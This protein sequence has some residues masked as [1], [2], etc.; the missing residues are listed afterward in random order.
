MGLGR[1]KTQAR[2]SAVEWRSKTPNVLAFS[3]EAHVTMP[4]DAPRQKTRKP[5]SSQTS[6]ARHTSCVSGTMCRRGLVTAACGNK[7]L[8][9]FAPYTF[10]FH[11]A[12]VNDCRTTTPN[13]MATLLPLTPQLQTCYGASNRC[14]LSANNGREQMQQLGA[15]R[16]TRSPHQHGQAGRTARQ[17]RAC[18][19]IAAGS[20]PAHL[21]SICTLSPSTQPNWPNTCAN[22]ATLAC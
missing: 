7:I 15:V 16:T 5:R 3:R 2:C 11:T 13:V 21:T 1:A 19:R 10:S 6:G 17:C 12:R 18:R 4:T 8:T 22:V 20:P 14:T 9:I